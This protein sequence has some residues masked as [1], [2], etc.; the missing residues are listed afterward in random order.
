MTE[1]NGLTTTYLQ[2]CRDTLTRDQAAS[3]AATNGWAHVDRDEVHADW[4]EIYRELAQN[5][6]QRN[7]EDDATQALIDRHYRIACQFYTPSKEAYIGM[8]LSYRENQDMRVFHNGYHQDMVE[9]LIPAIT[10]YARHRL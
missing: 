6:D 2:T 8:A 3:F 5:I 1:N 9:F 4:D 7:P 10:T